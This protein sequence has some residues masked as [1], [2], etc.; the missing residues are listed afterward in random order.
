MNSISKQIRQLLSDQKTEWE[1]AGKNFAG[2]ENVQMREFQFEGFSVKV[3]FNP[4]RIV[5]SA[6]KV[7]KKS[8]ESRPCFLCAANRPAEQRGVTFGDYEVLVNPFPIF[9]EHFTIPAFAHTLQQIKGNFGNML[10][11]AQAMEGFTLFYNGPKCG[12]SAPDHFHFQA[13]NA[14]FMPLDEGTAALKEKY[15]DDWEKDDVNYSAIKDGLRNF[16]VLESAN[17]MVLINAFAHIYSALEDS[18]SDEEPMLNI[19]ARYN[20]NGWIILVFPR[21]LHRPSQY[22]AEGEEN[23]LISPASVDMGGVLITPQEKDF[24]KIGKADIE[25][26][27]KQVLL[28][29]D[30]FDKLIVKLKQ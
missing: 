9:P 25:S 29:E 19:L 27:L 11:L 26:I 7:D 5:S 6:A 24:L 21:A 22:F 10:D 30:Q 17:K 8:I 18:Q 3:Q 20:E 16:L 28:P 14:G 13:G 2:L 4:G 15:G 1:L 23:I 12:A